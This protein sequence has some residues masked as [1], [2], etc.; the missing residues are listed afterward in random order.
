[1][2]KK[3]QKLS[4]RSKRCSKIR[5]SKCKK[6]M[7]SLNNTKVILCDLKIE[8]VLH[9]KKILSFHNVSIRQN[10]HQNRLINE[11]ARKNLA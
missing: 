3:E 1:M 2:L 7:Q 9:F 5:H 8:V 4:I 11:C 6:L 10:F